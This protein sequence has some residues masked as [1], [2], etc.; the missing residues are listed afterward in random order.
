MEIQY[1]KKLGSFFFKDMEG[2]S[3][4]ITDKMLEVIRRR[5][6]IKTLKDEVIRVKLGLV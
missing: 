2:E 4:V 1:D 5:G 3:F 6:S